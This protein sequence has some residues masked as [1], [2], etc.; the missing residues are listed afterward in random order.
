M[1]LYIII[2]IALVSTVSL[3]AAS[4]KPSKEGEFLE[5]DLDDS[6]D[7][8]KDRKYDWRGRNINQN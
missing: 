7:I 6:E 2:S 1:I 5:T 4:S 8:L 3:L